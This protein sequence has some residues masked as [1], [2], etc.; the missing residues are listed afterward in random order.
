MSDN[1]IDDIEKDNREISLTDQ[2]LAQKFGDDLAPPPVV[3][4]VTNLTPAQMRAA[5]AREA[6]ALKAQQRLTEKENPYT[7]E[8]SQER[9][10]YSRA[11]L[12]MISVRQPKNTAE[13]DVCKAMAQSLVDH[14][15]E[16]YGA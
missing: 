15:K 13:L 6:K 5:K 9:D 14:V 2:I 12:T 3:T 11:L 16:K 8:P 1:M 7:M 10:F 4:E